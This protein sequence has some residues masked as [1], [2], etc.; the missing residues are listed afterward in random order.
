MH[1]P[2]FVARLPIRSPSFQGPT[3]SRLSVVYLLGF[4]LVPGGAQ[5]EL[6]QTR[7]RFVL[8]GEGVFPGVTHDPPISA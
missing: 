5:L 2:Q 6:W 7:G 1:A 8:Q 3:R 4:C